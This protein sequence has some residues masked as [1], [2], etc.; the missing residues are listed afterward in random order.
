MERR[1]LNANRNIAPPAGPPGPL[2]VLVRRPADRLGGGPLELLLDQARRRGWRLLNVALTDGSLS[3]ERTPAG[4]LVTELP[5]N[6]TVIRLHAMGCP[7]VRLGQFE[8]PDDSDL[9]A[10]LPDYRRAGRMAV[11]HFAQR[12]YRH[13]AMFGHA[14]M[15]ATPWVEAGM[16]ERAEA[17]ACACDQYLLTNPTARTGQSISR[18]DLYDERH[19]AIAAWLEAKPKPF[20]L[21][22]C[23]TYYAG[24]ISLICQQSGV[25]IPEDAA[26]L[27]VGDEAEICELT[28]V[29]IS[30]IDMGLRDMMNVAIDLLGRLIDGEPVPPRTF[31]APTGI[32]TR[33]STD[34]LAVAHPMV[35]RAIRYIWDRL[36]QDVTV[37]EVAS[38]M[39]IPRHKLERLFREHFQRG[40]HAEL[41]RARLER[42]AELLRTTDLPV[43]ELAP[44]VGFNSPQFLHDSFCKKYQTTPR[45]YR[46]KAQS[47]DAGKE[48]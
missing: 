17:L 45:Q 33:R 31:V 2:I 22:A 19:A 47:P 8:H 30:A 43:R 21:L 25:A 36:D 23:N 6:P 11:E 35:A 28:S 48:T 41:R 1:P 14:A 12:G 29:P 42:F 32:V 18:P 46:L 4:A 15:G 20:G 37:D 7:I 24:M 40:I 38:A 16:R 34:I 9:P 27:S 3:G 13:L 44:R 5:D 26:I 39:R 10:V